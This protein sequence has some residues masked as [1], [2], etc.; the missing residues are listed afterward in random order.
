[1]TSSHLDSPIGGL[2][3]HSDGTSLTAIEFDA[4]PS[5]DDE[6]D[7]VLREGCRQL[8]EYFT[9]ER[10]VFE[11]ALAPD[12]TE[13]QRRVWAAL[14]TIPYGRTATYGEIATCLGLE[15]GASRAVGAANGAN[16]L[17][18]VVPCHRVIGSNGALVGY[19]G[20]IDRKRTLLMLESPGLF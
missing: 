9:G 12:G 3:L 8:R 6:G 15:P 20:G 5:G 13:F 4:S 7:D 17:P 18:I 14:E 11:L 10:H 1:M 19:G 2:R 16:P